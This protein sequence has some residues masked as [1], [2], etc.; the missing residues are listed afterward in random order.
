MQLYHSLSKFKFLN[1]YSYKFL[2]I[3]FLGIHV[4][5]LGLIFFIVLSPEPK[6][7]AGT[8]ITFALIFTLLATAITLY[9]LHSLIQPLRLAQ[10]ALT[11]YIAE[12]KIPTLPTQYTDEVGVLLH[13]IQF[14]I[15]ELNN[16]LEEKKDLISMLSHDLRSPVLTMLDAISLLRDEIDPETLNLYLDEMEKMGNK[17]LDLVHSVLKL[18]KYES[19]NFK[20]SDLKPL[21]IDSLMREIADHFEL[22]LLKKNIKL[23]FN[24][25]DAVVMAEPAVFSQVITN[26][27]VNAIKFSNKKGDIFIE[28]HSD[29]LKTTIQFRDNG[30]GFDP[31]VSEDL[32]N[33]FT[34]HRKTGTNGEA[35]N[36]LG[37][38]LCRQ[39]IQKQDGRIYAHSAGKNQGATFTIEIP[40][41]FGNVVKT[42]KIAEPDL[43]LV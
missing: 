33:K 4:P 1:R 25:N 35:T 42:S 27:L 26:V 30:L 12:K 37:L 36:G 16:L 7:S 8:V 43:V 28:S 5:L 17:Q 19:G 24:L 13:D 9:I 21:K 15:T 3:A 11:T 10:T 23:H 32:F 38:Y 34:K 14:T 39:M 2:F 22:P 29:E 20:K 41:A 18:L 40:N 6:F 31:S